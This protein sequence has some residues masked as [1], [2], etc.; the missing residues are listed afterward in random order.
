[1]HVPAEDY[2]AES[3]AIFCDLEELV[4]G[5]ELAAEDT[6]DVAAG[7]FDGVVI[8]EDVGEV[9]EGHCDFRHV[10]IVTKSRESCG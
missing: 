4:F 2:T 5:H 9:L 10:A 6:V 7:D 1:M 3:E 8:F